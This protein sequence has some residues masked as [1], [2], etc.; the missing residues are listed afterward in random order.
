[1]LPS[2]TSELLVA[3]SLCSN[4][5]E[6]PEY[7]HRFIK[8][9]HANKKAAVSEVRFDLLT[10]VILRL[11][12]SKDSPFSSVRILALQGTQKNTKKKEARIQGAIRASQ[13]CILR[14]RRKLL[15]WSAYTSCA[16]VLSHICCLNLGEYPFDFKA[17]KKV[18][19]ER[20]TG[21]S[22][23]WLRNANFSKPD[24]HVNAPMYRQ[25][26]RVARQGVR[27]G[28]SSSSSSSSSSTKPNSN[29]RS[30]SN[31]GQNSS[32]TRSKSEICRYLAVLVMHS[33]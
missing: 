28:S 8:H 31:P 18:L 22:F 13:V 33:P 6:M 1:M 19:D 16:W 32:N 29:N 3:H 26:S 20:S 2:N 24:A 17:S 25:A 11:A 14:V 4:F 30:S 7:Q 5:L 10:G 21:S 12:G 15:L 27:L 9:G 23:A